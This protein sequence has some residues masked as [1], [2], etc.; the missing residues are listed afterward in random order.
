MW[1]G[2]CFWFERQSICN[3]TEKW[4]I[5]SSVI[6]KVNGR[7]VAILDVLAL[8]STRVARLV[9]LSRFF[10][11]LRPLL[12]PLEA[13]SSLRSESLSLPWLV[14][15]LGMD[16]G[17]LGLLLSCCQHI[18]ERVVR[19]ALPVKKKQGLVNAVQISF[20]TNIFVAI[21]FSNIHWWIVVCFL[22]FCF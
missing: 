3:T 4:P 21:G 16:V 15:A 5:S 14:L 17:L 11:F 2:S 18:V 6:S 1:R 10:Y 19:Y 13:R 12:G 20:G 9:C 22:F 7:R 8:V